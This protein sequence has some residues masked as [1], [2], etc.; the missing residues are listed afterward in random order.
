MQ[1][2]SPTSETNQLQNSLQKSSELIDDAAAMQTKFFS[3]ALY[4]ILPKYE[5]LGK[6]EKKLKFKALP[7][8]EINKI[9]MGTTQAQR[10][11]ELWKAASLGR[12]L[13]LVALYEGGKRVKCS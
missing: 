5:N 13:R 8:L 4:E 1:K 12:C 6:H 10:D 11:E 9:Q 7:R 2:E 3:R